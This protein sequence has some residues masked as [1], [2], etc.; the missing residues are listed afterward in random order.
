MAG[1]DRFTNEEIESLMTRI[2]LINKDKICLYPF[3]Q[4]YQCI[5]L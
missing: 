5:Y 1:E 3:D 4:Y 2:K